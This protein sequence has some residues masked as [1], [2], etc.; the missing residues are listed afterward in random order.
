MAK[1]KI[2]LENGKYVIVKEVKQLILFPLRGHTDIYGSIAFRGKGAVD[3]TKFEQSGAKVDRVFRWDML[4][5]STIDIS[6]ELKIV[7]N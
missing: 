4:A 1:I 6:G 7:K 5:I 3:K 2:K